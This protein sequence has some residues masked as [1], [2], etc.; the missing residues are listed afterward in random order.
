MKNKIIGIL[1]IVMILFAIIPCTSLSF[2]PE[3][4]KNI[5]EKPTGSDTL[6]NKGKSILGV[7]QV[8]GMGIAVIMLVIIGVKYITASVE[9]KAQLK[10]T[11]MPYVIGAI[12]LFGGSGILTIVVN[13]VR[14]LEI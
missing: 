1:I 5:Y 14:E 13:F 11:L 3:D 2:N 12:L 6:L 9:E 7:V 4:Y 10:E 8:V